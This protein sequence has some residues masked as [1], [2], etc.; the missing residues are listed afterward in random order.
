MEEKEVKM[1]TLTLDPLGES[2]AVEEPK[3]K[4]VEEALPESDLEES[5]L[6]PEEKKLVED[7]SEK[8]D[9]T[10]SQLVLQYGAAAQNKISDFQN[11]LWIKCVQKTLAK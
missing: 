2:A 1:P 4:P 11:L 8:I 5:K 10:N 6:T 7:F 3:I 9:I